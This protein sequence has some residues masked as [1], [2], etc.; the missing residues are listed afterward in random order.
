MNNR[1]EIQETSVNSEHAVMLLNELNGVLAEITGASGEASFSADDVCHARSAFLIAYA[2]GSAC[3]CGALRRYSGHTAEIK[4]VYARPNDLGIGSAILE[5]LEEKARSFGYTKLILETRRVNTAA[6]SFY[7]RHG[8]F[9]RANYG[10]Y[11]NREN[12][13]CMA[14]NL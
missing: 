4:R 8:Y 6:V 10:K 14:K 3:G 7:R 1:I 5:A 13:I 11:A 2:D 9:A 12:A